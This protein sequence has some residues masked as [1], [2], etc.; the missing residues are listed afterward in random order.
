[1]PKMRQGI[2]SIALFVRSICLTGTFRII[3]CGNGGQRFYLF[4][5]YLFQ[6]FPHQTG[7]LLYALRIGT[8]GIRDGEKSH[9]NPLYPRREAFSHL[10]R[11]S[12]GGKIE[13]H[14]NQP[15]LTWIRITLYPGPRTK[16]PPEHHNWKHSTSH[17]AVIQQHGPSRPRNQ[18]SNLSL[19]PRCHRTGS[20]AMARFLHL[21]REI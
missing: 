5:R 16:E 17:T 18:P 11:E 21:P 1:M 12:V 20:T 14:I 6:D 4:P 15:N 9:R 3:Q 8:L 10:A 7:P 13:A 2:G 19:G